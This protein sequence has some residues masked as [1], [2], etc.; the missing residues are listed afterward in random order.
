M[1]FSE[2]YTGF[3]NNIDSLLDGIDIDLANLEKIGAFFLVIGYSNFI[4]AANLDILETLNINNTNVS[5]ISLFILGQK[6]VLLGYTILLIVALRR[7]NNKSSRNTILNENS[8]IT[9][10]NKIIYS[11]ILSVLANLIRLEAFYEIS[12]SQ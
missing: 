6:V 5:S 4:P 10:Y 2:N 1:D 7:T 9:A 8:S 11:Y 3:F 12:K